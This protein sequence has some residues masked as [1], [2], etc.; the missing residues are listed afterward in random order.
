[1]KA[2]RDQLWLTYAIWGVLM[3]SA[4]TALATARWPVAFV[5]LATILVSMLPMILAPRLGLHLP[6]RFIAVIVLFVFATLFLGEV[7][8]FYE[9]YWWWDIA[10]HGLSAVG[11]GL[12]GFLLVFILFEGDRYAAPAW[13]LGMIAFC[14]GVT[15]GVTWEIFEFG[16]DQI[17]GLNMQKSG[18]M[19]TMGDL[20]VDC[21]GAGI[22]GLTGYLYLKGRDLGGSRAVIDE[23]IHHNRRFFRRSG[24]RRD[25]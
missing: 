9:R 1:M 10:L 25:R 11:F 16:M 2:L 6:R 8:D 12:I 23:F 7:Y 14:M 18:L 24:K 21:I 19:D 4:L 5:A 17:F 15:I 13:A 3:L 22:G 20:I